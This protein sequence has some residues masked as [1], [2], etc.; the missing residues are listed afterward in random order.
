[1]FSELSHWGFCGEFACSPAYI[2]YPNI[3][4]IKTCTVK[5]HMDLTPAFL[6]TA[7]LCFLLRSL[8]C[9]CLCRWPHSL[10][11]CACQITWSTKGFFKIRPEREKS[12]LLWLI[13]HSSVERVSPWRVPFAA[14]HSTPIHPLCFVCTPQ[15]AHFPRWREPCQSLLTLHSIDTR[16]TPA[17]ALQ[18]SERIKGPQALSCGPYGGRRERGGRDR[19]SL[20][21][22]RQERRQDRCSEWDGRSSAAVTLSYPSEQQ[23]GTVLTPLSWPLCSWLLP[24]FYTAWA[25]GDGAITAKS[26]LADVEVLQRRWMTQV[27]LVSLYGLSRAF[28]FLQKWEQK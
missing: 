18:K 17:L 8:V 15:N 14:I 2:G 11:L 3:P 10:H 23:T 24:S 16:G 13:P 12:L 19:E 9:V 22:W 5:E 26:S 7:Y 28:W 6:D 25:R 1:M 20:C 21:V 27:Y 4:N